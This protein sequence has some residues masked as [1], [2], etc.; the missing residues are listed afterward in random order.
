VRQPT[1]SIPAPAPLIDI[2][3]ELVDIGRKLNMKIPGDAEGNQLR[4]SKH[5]IYFDCSKAWREL[6][7]PQVD[8]YESVLDTYQWYKQQGVI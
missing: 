8:I 6:Y 2:V 3:A 5:N 4:M 1:P 7:E